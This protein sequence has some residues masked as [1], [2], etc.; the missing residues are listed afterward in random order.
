MNILIT[1]GTGFIGSRLALKCLENGH[2]VTILGQENTTAESENRKLLESK[3]VNITLGSVTESDKVR[4]VCQGIDLVYHLAAAQHEAN[5]PDQHFWEVNVRGTRNLL[6]AS[7]GARVKRFVHGSTIGVYGSALEGTIDEQSAV[8]PDN[9]YGVTK[10]E[11]EKVVLSYQDRIPVVIVRI[12]ETYGPGDRR[13][14]KL[15]KAIKRNMFFTIGDGQNLHHVIFIDDLVDGL[16]LAAAVR[17]AAGGIFVLAGRDRVT[18]ND[19]AAVIARQLDARLG[20]IRVPLF[21]FL[22]IATLLEALL[23][24]LGIQPP[25]HRRRMDFFKKSFVFSQERAQKVLGF[26]PKMSFEQGVAVTSRWYEQM[27]YL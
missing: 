11:G 10:L 22:F 26:V 25:L 6:E 18:T 3:G 23:R 5:V 8:K 1:G 19:M 14:L 7:L 20:R 27:G 9:I 24:P 21:P 17:E 16:I 2:R 13:L 12:S 15:F 4:E